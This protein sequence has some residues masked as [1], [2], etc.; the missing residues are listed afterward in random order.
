MRS[1]TGFVTR[2]A[3]RSR[4]EK[5]VETARGVAGTL[6]SEN[7]VSESDVSESDGVVLIRAELMS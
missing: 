4:L 2:T 6:F 7:N 3:D 1:E 5:Q